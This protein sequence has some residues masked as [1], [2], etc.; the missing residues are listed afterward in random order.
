M[1]SPDEIL[2]ACSPGERRLALVAGG[3]V[4]EFWIDRGDAAPG[5]I[6]LGRVVSVNKAL[7][8]AFVEIGEPLPGIL[9]KPGAL[10]EGQPVMVQL[11]ASARGD[12]GAE[13][14]AAVSL[15]GALLAYSPHRA[16]LNLSRKIEDADQRALLSGLLKPALQ[17]GEG[18]VVRTQAA[19]A[20]DAALL[21]ELESLRRDWAGLSAQQA[22]PPAR[23]RSPSALQRWL[24]E[25]SSVRTVW[26]D[27]AAAL[28]E[29]PLAKLDRAAFARHD[30]DELLEAALAPTVALPGGGRLLIGT[31][32][33]MTV[34]DIDS[35][36]QSPEQANLAAVPEIARQIRLRGLSG[37]I[38]VD[39]IPL[40][41]RRAQGRVLDALRAA[42]AQDPTP[43][44][45]SGTTPLGL[46]EILRDRR[47]PSL[48]EMLLQETLPSRSPEAQ[49]LEALAALLREAD[50]R[51][52]RLLGLEL[53]PAAVAALRRRPAA[54]TEA[55]RRLGHALT[56]RDRPGLDHPQI[57]ELTP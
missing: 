36:G 40:K 51:P 6:L 7:N 16:G 26:L 52:G 56:L 38:L 22:E 23:L 53:S 39:V 9:P 33:G 8:A 45:L 57:I 48:A 41:D 50:S 19:E 44:H 42:L 43:C 18:L 3:Q 21:A 1:P 54:I 15:Q 17:P 2:I 12:K 25:Y 11:T 10:S 27:D 34:I 28:A 14:T 55:E 35:G 5:D 30:A 37:R 20:D 31:A 24:A 13:L 47:R 46:V 49:G 29:T 4:L 32:A